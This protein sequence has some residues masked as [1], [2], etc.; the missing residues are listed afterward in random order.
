MVRECS[1][2][3]CRGRHVADS[4]F[5]QGKNHIPPKLWE[6]IYPLNR[7]IAHPPLNCQEKP[8]PP[9][10]EVPFVLIIKTT[11]IHTVAIYK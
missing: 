5:C 10:G 11:N 4:H 3:M 9:K 2:I 1:T 8:I 7:R 6:E